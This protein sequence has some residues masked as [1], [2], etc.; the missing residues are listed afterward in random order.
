MTK[1]IT[2]LQLTFNIG[3]SSNVVLGG[4]HE[5]IVNDPIRLMIQTR[6]RMQL[7]DLVILDGQVVAC[8]FQMGNLHEESLHECLANV[9]VVVF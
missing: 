5:F 2:F 6:R 8:S 3:N 4:Q 7:N 1:S 9:D